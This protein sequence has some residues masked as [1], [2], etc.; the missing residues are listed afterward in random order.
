[1]LKRLH[2]ILGILFVLALLY[3]FW[4]WGGLSLHPTFGAPVNEATGRELA[5]ATIYVPAGNT[6]LPLAG[7]GAVA[8]NHA[9]ALFA[10][11]L[12]A[13]QANPAA[14]MDTLVADMPWSARIAYHGAPLL[15]VAFLLAYW[16]RPR[17][18]RSAFSRR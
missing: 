15:L 14:A 10:P 12:P 8:A 17:T 6:L 1:M 3:D 5:L 7:L 16:R 11:L 18:V 4:I 13:L 9:G 2:V